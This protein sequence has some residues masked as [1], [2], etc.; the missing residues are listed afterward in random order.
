MRKFLHFLFTL[1]AVCLLTPQAFSQEK[2]VTGK[3]LDENNQPLSG[4]T[5][6]VK[7]SSR[8]V[9]TAADGSFSIK[10][11]KGETIEI[12]HVGFEGRS[13]K[14]GDSNTLQ[15][16]MK[17]SETSMGEVVVTAMDIKRS[18]KEL[19]YSVQKVSGAE[20]QQTQRENFVNGLQGRVAGLTVN[21]STGLAGASSQ[22]VLR[23]FNSL[24]SNNQPLFVVDGIILDNQTMNET[25]N[26]G[27]A[28]GLA[29]D[30]A[31]RNND[32]TNRIADLN[33]SDIESITILK[34]PEA[35]AL[36]G[37]QA[38]SG[39]IVITT[40]KATQGNKVKV[41]YDNSF[42]ISKLT[43]YFDL[44]NNY[45]NGSNGV[46]SNSFS[47]T[48]GSFFGPKYPDGT[49][50]YNNI[51]KFFQTAFSQAHNLSVD[52]G[53]N[54]NMGFRFSGSFLD[55]TGVVPNNSYT[56]YNFRLTNSTKI[57]K[58]VELT[59]SFQYIHSD[60][61]KP[62]RSAGGYLLSLY[63]WPVTNDITKFEDADG[64]KISVYS[65]DPYA[66]I[67]NPLYTVKRNVSEDKN[68][69][70]I[71]SG[72]INITPLSW[73]TIAGR[74]GYDA[75][76]QKGYTLY[77]PM[78]YLT[79]R[80]QLGQLDNYW[81]KY[82]GYNHTI[83]ATAT[84][85]YKQF[86][87][88]IMAGTMWQDFQTKMFAIYGTGL[89]DSIGSSL[90]PV[91]YNKLYKSGQI[92]TDDNFGQLIGSPWDSSITRPGTR[93]RLAQNTYGH[94][95][96]YIVEQLAFFGEVGIGY[97][98]FLFLNYTQRSET[99][100]VFPKKN[101]TYNFPGFSASAII[102]DMFPALKKGPLN[103][104]KFRASSA[105]VARYF[106]PYFNQSVFVN[107]LTSSNVGVIYNYGFDNNNPDLKPEKQQTYEMGTELRLFNSLLGFELTYYNT[108]CTN[109]LMRQFRAS[110]GTGYILNTQN[111]GSL[112]NEGIEITADLAPLRTQNFS[113]NIRFNFD[114]KWS[115]V[116]TLPKSIGYEIYYSDTWLYGNA[117]VG[118][119]RDNPTT[120]I[121]GFH[122][123]RNIYGD[124]LINPSTG[125]PVV[126]GT[127]TPIGDRNPDFKLGI[128]NNF[129]YKE[130][131][132]SFLWDT[133]VGG[134]VFDGT[135]MYL[136]LQGKSK[137]T[138][139]RE[140]PRVVD[141]VLNDGLQNTAYRTRNTIAI[142]PYYLQSYYTGMPE[143]E[144]VQHNVNYFWLKDLTLT[145]TMP[146]EKVKKLGYVKS[147]AFFFTGNDLVIFTNYKGADPAV[148]GNTAA[149]GAGVGSF[150]FDYGSLPAPVALNFGLR[151][152]F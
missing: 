15:V 80:T 140:T 36:Y 71:I 99:S 79:T 61:V 141:G 51:D 54:K 89:A 145:Y 63:A 103:Y 50:K 93:I 2:T 96:K 147:L 45:M 23:G 102:T 139:D 84:K 125:L 9:Q 120:T 78:S 66:E 18:P 24:S 118:L 133:K 138:S 109:Q 108:H 10:V 35:T 110:Y 37:S 72:G 47:A 123:M 97:H 43:R 8:T 95:N 32:Y 39:A 137:R 151:V 13:F 87:G 17:T 38:G 152:G 74:F 146:Q 34:G 112:R 28:L 22:I 11:S 44:D 83:T 142:T 42:R 98:D 148:N 101:R 1:V 86:K 126:E 77:H 149:N 104:W 136:T 21:P 29:S 75:Y 7:G 81:R 33:P 88:H 116:L 65:A 14:I 30:R 113:W 16:N 4:V 5:V 6:K 134:D 41:N 119:I 115:K 56:K 27:T 91:G 111:A 19:G 53:I 105:T 49:V 48:S 135:E 40:K 67:D 90:N 60:N 69:R 94:Y 57:G 143:E 31:N 144:F 20:I 73:L 131:S 12:S 129:R 122:Y 76:D 25:S 121:T 92:V 85:S 106:D 128:Q 52:Y 70:Y 68:D 107:N 117:R 150:A 64:N 3:V 82:F 59:P 46:A 114:H 130:W 62:L 132:L 100:S 26:G 55:Q 58:Y 124:I 127:F